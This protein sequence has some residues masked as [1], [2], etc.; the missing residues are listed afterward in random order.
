MKAE[1]LRRSAHP[2]EGGLDLISM[3]VTYPRFIHAECKTHRIM[4]W[5]DECVELVQA[6]AMMDD[7]SLSRNASSSRALPVS[8]LIHEAKTNPALPVAWHYNQAG[9]QGTK[10]MSPEDE[11]AAISLW[12]AAR[13][14]TLEVVEEMLKLNP[15]KQTINRLLEPF[16]H[17]TCVV[18]ATD[19]SNFFTLRLDDTADPTMQRLATL[20][21]DVIT[22]AP[23]KESLWPNWHT[24][25]VSDA[26]CETMTVHERL[27]ASA[28]RAARTSYLNHDGSNP[29]LAKDLALAQ[30]L[31][32]QWHMTPFEHQARPI[33]AHLRSGPLLGWESQRTSMERGYLA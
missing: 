4:P 11:A 27:L 29:Q 24:V 21:A 23:R 14:R 10:I 17:I 25:F 20:M 22:K 19:W 33:R 32:D 12:L 8:R 1:V 7:P 3:R 13:D 9:M 30:L 2:E 31:R 6:I 26:E 5:H 18:T 28:A 15:H 16:T